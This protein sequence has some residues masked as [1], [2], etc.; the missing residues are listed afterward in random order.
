MVLVQN[1]F[2][3]CRGKADISTEALN[4]VIKINVTALFIVFYKAQFLD[5][6]ESGYAILSNVANPFSEPKNR[7]SSMK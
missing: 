7:T 2:G 1:I 3:L 5:V 4:R 6:H